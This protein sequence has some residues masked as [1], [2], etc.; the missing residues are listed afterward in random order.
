VTTVRPR[1]AIRELGL[2]AN[3][4]ILEINGKRVKSP[5][6]LQAKL[7]ELSYGAQ[8]TM[9]VWRNKVAVDLP[10]RGKERTQRST[11]VIQLENP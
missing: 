8:V 4:L 5:D 1:G 10:Q 2:L 7:A 11:G 6:D 9:R 3:D